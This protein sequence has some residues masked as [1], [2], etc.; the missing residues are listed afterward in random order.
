MHSF[1]SSVAVRRFSHKSEAFLRQKGGDDISK[2]IRFVDA[3]GKDAAIGF[4]MEVDGFYVDFD[5]PKKEVLESLNLS[6]NIK[7]DTHLA[8]HR[9]K[10][11]NDVDLPPEM[12]DFERDWIHQILLSAAIVKAIEDDLT[13]RQAADMVLD[14]AEESFAQVMESL[15]GDNPNP[16]DRR[17]EAKISAR[18]EETLVLKRLR[19]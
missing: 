5:L 10:W 6:S 19:K 8:Y 17:L 4:E 9:Q 18:I 3:E 16:D 14:D 2:L 12:G 13:L 1:R 11:L 15:F 7:A